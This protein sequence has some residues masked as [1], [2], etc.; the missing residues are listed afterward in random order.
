M[1]VSRCCR[2]LY[3]K[4]YVRLCEIMAGVESN[5]CRYQ[6][7][8]YIVIGRVCI[9]KLYRLVS[10]WSRRLVQLKRYGKKKKKQK[11]RTCSFFRP[12]PIGHYYRRSL[13]SPALGRAE[14]SQI[15]R[16]SRCRASRKRKGSV[17]SFDSG[18][19]PTNDNKYDR[20]QKN[21]K[22]KWK[23]SEKWVDFIE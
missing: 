4:K 16:R 13:S 19:K 11:D 21:K 14:C 3:Y 6:T 18:T 5:R 7:V 1:R 12:L 20:K 23:K 15:R 8:E 22:K 2:V 17:R 9:Y 10:D